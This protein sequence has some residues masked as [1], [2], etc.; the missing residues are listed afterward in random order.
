MTVENYQGVLLAKLVSVQ[1]DKHPS[2]RYRLHERPN[3][4]HQSSE[5]DVYK[6][7]IV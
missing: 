6:N 7:A 1:L 3:S 5:W 4:T 2:L